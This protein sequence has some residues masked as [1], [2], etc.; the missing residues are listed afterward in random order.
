[1]TRTIPAIRREVTVGVDRTR[2]FEI[3]TADMT[4]WWPPA[5]HIGSAPIAQIVVEPHAG[6]RWYTRHEDGTETSTGV[7]TVWEP[8]ERV[9]VTWQ[10]GADWR[11][12]DDLV[13]TVEVVFIELEPGRTQVVLE[14]RDLEAFGADA[15]AMHGTF[16]QHGAWTATLE[17]YAAVAG[18]AS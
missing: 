9:V 6:G 15:D 17:A 16:D 2:A 13:T 4:S 10:I 18:A 1:M 12:H 3:F 14:H 5:H 7:V 8:P 11:F